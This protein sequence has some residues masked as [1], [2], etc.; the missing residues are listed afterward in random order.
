MILNAKKH[1][2]SYYYRCDCIT[3]QPYFYS[4]ILCMSI[5]FSNFSIFLHLFFFISF[6]PLSLFFDLM[7]RAC[8]PNVIQNPNGWLSLVCLQGVQV[9]KEENYQSSRH[10]IRQLRDRKSIKMIS[11]THKYI[12]YPPHLCIVTNKVDSL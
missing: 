10:N 2:A 9:R 3:A 6:A 11:H 12:H 5:F 1:K 8:M 7:F 4:S